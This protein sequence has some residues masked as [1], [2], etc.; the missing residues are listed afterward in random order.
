MYEVYFEIPEVETQSMTFEK[1]QEALKFVEP[2]LENKEFL[3]RIHRDNT[4][5]VLF[6]DKY[7]WHVSVAEWEGENNVRERIFRSSDRNK[8][9]S[10]VKS[11]LSES[12]HFAAV[13]EVVRLHDERAE[14]KKTIREKSHQ[15]RVKKAKLEWNSELVSVILRLLLLFVSLFFTIKVLF[16]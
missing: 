7:T 16:F 4:G 12:G 15:T 6:K 8:T 3:L 5:V 14:A 1:R 11:F 9:A 13:A 10:V 2:L